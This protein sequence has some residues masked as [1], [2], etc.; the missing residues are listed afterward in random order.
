MNGP[1][2]NLRRV[3]VGACTRT[4]RRDAPVQRH[5]GD[6]RALRGRV[7]PKVR[8]Q[9]GGDGAEG[10]DVDGPVAHGEEAAAHAPDR[11]G[12]IDDGD[13]VEGQRLAYA[14]QLGAQRDE[15]Q[16]CARH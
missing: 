12:G 6:E 1:A 15:R 7:R 11:R 2:K 9:R 5:N 10:H 3:G 16:C 4:G 8:E 14:D 13:Q